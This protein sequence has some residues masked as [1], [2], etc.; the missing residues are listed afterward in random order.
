MKSFTASDTLNL[1][2][3]ERIQLV[4]DIW[5]TIVSNAESIELTA[6]EKKIINARLDAFHQDPDSGSSWKDAFNR[7]TNH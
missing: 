5:D 4:E 6:D 7:I 3:P 2:V 1:S